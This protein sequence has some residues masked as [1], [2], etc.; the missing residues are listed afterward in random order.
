MTAA[1]QTARLAALSKAREAYEAACVLLS[2]RA[3]REAMRLLQ[4]CL[5]VSHS[6]KSRPL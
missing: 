2:E 6:K 1:E 3:Y 4:S 5:Q